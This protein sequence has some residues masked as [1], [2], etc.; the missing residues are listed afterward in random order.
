LEEARRAIAEARQAVNEA[1]AELAA[2]EQEERELMRAMLTRLA[3]SLEAPPLASSQ[4][5]LETTD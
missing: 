2:R 3:L 4:D 1:R 5:D